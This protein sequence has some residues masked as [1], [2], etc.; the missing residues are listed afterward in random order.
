MKLFAALLMTALL[1]GCG[2]SDMKD[3]DITLSSHDWSVTQIGA[4][5]VTDVPDANRPLLKFD[6]ETY[7]ASGVAGCNNFSCNYKI[8][9]K[10]NILTFGLMAITKMACEHGKVESAFTKALEH[11][12]SMELKGDRLILFDASG[13]EVL[14]ARAIK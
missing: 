3:G 1:V 9:E 5:D 2:S 10:E 14:E 7:K 12:S 8:A 13:V 4:M 6:A 11:V